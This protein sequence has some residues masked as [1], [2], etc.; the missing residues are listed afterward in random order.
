MANSQ[1]LTWVVFASFNLP[2]VAI[3]IAV[4]FAK[5]LSQALDEKSPTGDST[6]VTSYSRVTGALGAVVL[7][8]FFW[9]VGNILLANALEMADVRKLT[10]LM[11]SLSRYFL[12]G[13]ALFLPYAFNQLKSLFPWSASATLAA[14]QATLLK[15]TLPIRYGVDEVTRIG[16][17]NLSS[18]VSDD[19]LRRVLGAIATQIADDF[20]P[21]WKQSA[22][23]S[24]SRLELSGGHAPVD[25]ATDA[26]IY[27]GDQSNN[28]TTGVGFARGFHDRNV[29]GRPYGFVFL[30][31]C[32]QYGEPWS[33][34]LS[35]EILELLADPT[36]TLS[37]QDPRQGAT[38]GFQYALE[39]CDPTQ[40]DYYEIGG[41]VV[42]NFVNRAFFC[43]PGGA[44]A[45]N[46]RQ[47]PQAPFV[48]RVKGYIQY[49]DE[50]GA[51]QQIWG[52]EVTD[53]QKA[54]RELLGS[55]RRNSRRMQRRL[56]RVPALAPELA[57][58]SML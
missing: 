57:K 38:G 14:A 12:I 58:R 22:T 31:V 42:A 54:A 16:V 39:V 15:M 41:V 33:A 18:K 40:G 9:A 49:Q 29:N 1:L 27:V 25:A 48:P 37:V 34:T 35:H 10:D 4:P 20:A 55:N 52:S 45:M 2:I 19:D 23:L 13:S 7:T 17:V 28:P 3:V 8:S 50:T 36:A 26:V 21:E 43:Q 47:L 56:L 32:A 5:Q 11:N 53:K 6:G 46:H 30:D 44:P 24:A 51:P